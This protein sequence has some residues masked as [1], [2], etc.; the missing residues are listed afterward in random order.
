LDPAG[1]RRGS[2]SGAHLIGSNLAA[3]T[4]DMVA[5]CGA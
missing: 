1:G 3:S 4:L 2:G 5:M